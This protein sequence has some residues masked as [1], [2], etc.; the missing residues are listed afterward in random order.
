MS[1]FGRKQNRFQG[2][3]GFS[4]FITVTIIIYLIISFAFF[5]LPVEAASY[6]RELDRDLVI[7][8]DPGHGGENEG[9]IENGFCEK[10]MTMTTAQA[11][12]D[13]LTMYDGVT[14]YLTRTEDRDL[15]LKERAEYAKSVGADF[16]FSI[17]Y[18]AS[19]NHE[20]FGSEVWVQLETPYNAYGYQFG[21]ILLTRLQEKGLF[22]RGIKT[23]KNDKGMNY[24]GI[25]RESA[26]LDIPAVIIEHCHVD[27]A[28][29]YGY[30]DTEEK[31][32]AFGYEDA[33]A[34]A[35]FLGLSGDNPETEYN[36]E[37]EDPYLQKIF[38]MDTGKVVQS[39]LLDAT[40]PE[41][42]T[43]ERVS[44]DYTGFHATIQVMA[45]DYD[46][47]MMYYSYSLDGGENYSDRQPWPGCN[48]L[49]GEYQDLFQLTLEI[50]DGI[51][52][53][54]RIKAYNQYEGYTESNIL[55]GYSVFQKPREESRLTE[56]QD[57]EIE[58]ETPTES[59]E[60]S[61][62]GWLGSMGENKQGEAGDHSIDI[63]DFILV[64]LLAALALLVLMMVL[65]IFVT[66]KKRR[67]HHSRKR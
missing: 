59:R 30:C 67:T 9:T 53:S 40:A 28:R 22:I 17:H 58:D 15:S 41:I 18:N 44:E 47:P 8:I 38:A 52:P 49:T 45:A 19:E 34:I 6:Y 50:P 4:K 13:R 1:S 43:I 25:L 20:L 27:E 55:D 63:Q 46:S 29:D 48:M 66:A 21:S 23:R 62:S 54:I 2:E 33:E 14:V 26:A 39:T 7:V 51:I 61:A 5:S 37:Q 11:L 32:E 24:Y 16:L 42:C 60:A 10:E 31:Q 36:G 3:T 65:Q 35:M 57:A 12:Y 64:S 56:E